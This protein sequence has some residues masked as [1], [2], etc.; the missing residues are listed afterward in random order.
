MNRW[1]LAASLVMALWVA[2]CEKPAPP[3]A[4]IRPVRV[5][6]VADVQEFVGRPHAAQAVANEE[7][8]LS[9]RV[10]GPLI[11]L[12]VKAGDRIKKGDVLA[13]IDPRDYEV[14]IRTIE[15]EL[16]AVEAKL[17]DANIEFEMVKKLVAQ[18]AA[19]AREV[20]RKKAMVDLYAG[21]KVATEGKLEAAR[22]E[23]SY[24]RLLAPFDG[25][26]ATTYV[27]N[28]QT[29][30]AKE[31]VVRLLDLT[32]VKV[33]I[34]LPEKVM[35]ALVYVKEINCT[36]Q[37]IPG[38]QFPARIH[39][40]ANEASRLTRTY[41]VTLIMDQPK[42]AEILPGMTGEVRGKA[43]LPANAGESGFEILPSALFQGED[44]KASVWL[45]DEAARKVKRQPVTTVRLNDNSVL[46]QGLAP[47]QLVVTAGAH[48]L[49]EGQ[50]VR[51]LE[52]SQ[53]A[54]PA[55]AQGAQP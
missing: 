38:R 41:R 9:L 25:M 28:F 32:R 44:G 13:R 47:G 27:D 16:A 48:F 39:E 26:I 8:D 30:Q 29:V 18:E 31:R 36:F 45:F 33:Q 12:P 35:P 5:M 1:T 34:D 40:V 15:G 3:P 6:K 55:A 46:V 51:L 53:P 24:T 11:E 42:D 49:K 22:D 10:G 52:E 54:T 2:G 19:A 50:E 20:D 4:A 17:K 14:K 21:Q 37:A 43:E 23:L 7:V